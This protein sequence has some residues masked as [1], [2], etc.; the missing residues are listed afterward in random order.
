[1]DEKF[2]NGSYQSMTD[3]DKLQEIRKIV[4]EYLNMLE[5][6]FSWDWNEPIERLVPILFPPSS[7]ED[8]EYDF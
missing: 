6:G 3:A 8:E 7:D 1:M 2:N 5:G 4:F